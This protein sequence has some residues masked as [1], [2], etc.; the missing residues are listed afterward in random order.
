MQK[1]GLSGGSSPPKKQP[2]RQLLKPESRLSDGTKSMQDFQAQE[3]VK[4]CTDQIQ[5]IE[6][7]FMQIAT[8][9]DFL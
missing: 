1:S 4:H 8:Q 7:P 3:A 6:S 2:I 5:P 9:E